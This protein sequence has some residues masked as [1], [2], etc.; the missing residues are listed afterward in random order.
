ML[1]DGRGGAQE[2]PEEVI[3]EA[4]MFGHQEIMKIVDWI[5][6][7]QQAVGKEKS[8]SSRRK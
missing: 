4:I 8:R 1:F 5:T 3:L 2:V 7:I 6:K